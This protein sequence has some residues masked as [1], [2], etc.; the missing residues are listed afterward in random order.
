MK[1]GPDGTFTISP[2][3]V[4]ADPA[5]YLK[6]RRMIEISLATLFPILLLA[7][8]QTGSI[9]GWWNRVFY[10]APS[11]VWHT[12]HKMFTERD[13]SYDIWVTLKRLLYGYFFGTTI[14]LLA[15]FVLG[16]SRITRRTLEPTMNALYTVPK[17]ALLSPFLIMFGFEDKPVVILVS[18]TVFFFVWIPTQASVMGVQASFREAATVFGANRWNTFRHVI[19]PAT[20]P[21]IFV[22]LRVAASVAILTVVGVEFVYAPEGR[23]L[24]YVINDARSTLNSGVAWAGI[25]VASLLGVLVTTIVKLIGRLVVPWSKEDEASPS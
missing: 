20:L 4:D 19:F 18:I 15:G 9:N 17:I 23:G 25:L 3:K 13:F 10:P 2:R 24:G 5:A 8:L 11:D 21:G 22:T 6:R 12:L 14:G 1:R 16:L 7:L